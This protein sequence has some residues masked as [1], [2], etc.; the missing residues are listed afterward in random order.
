MS[1]LDSSGM[2][3]LVQLQGDMR[4]K[5]LQLGIPDERALDIAGEMLHLV[6]ESDLIDPETKKEYQDLAKDN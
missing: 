4:V 5:L 6:A 3:K 2:L 1:N